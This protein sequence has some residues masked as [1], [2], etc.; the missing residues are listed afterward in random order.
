MNKIGLDT[1]FLVKLYARDL[2]A[3]ELWQE[4]VKQG[5]LL[6]INVLSIFEFL[7]VSLKA[8]KNY[9]ASI[10]F[11]DKIKQT[12]NILGV[13]DNLCLIASKLGQIYSLANIEALILTSFLE[14]GCEVILTTNKNFER[15]KEIETISV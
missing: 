12:S 4:I 5:Y 6:S 14:D 11:L 3:I 1:G 10:A 7:K 9:F 13:T 8:N 15:V 2:K